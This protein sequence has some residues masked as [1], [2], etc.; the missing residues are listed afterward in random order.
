[1][2]RWNQYFFESLKHNNTPFC[3]LSSQ[4]SSLRN[5]FS[6]NRFISQPF[7]FLFSSKWIHV[8]FAFRLFSFSLS[9]SAHLS[10][11]ILFSTHSCSTFSVSISTILQHFLI[12]Q[13]HF[14]R[15]QTIIQTFLLI[16]EKEKK[17]IENK[18]LKRNRDVEQ[19]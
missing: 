12:Y 1:M 17:W 6:H 10:I 9:C 11:F 14:V 19:T 7:S 3:E 2:T 15:C 5:H 13:Y 4:R 16:E 18:R 8:H